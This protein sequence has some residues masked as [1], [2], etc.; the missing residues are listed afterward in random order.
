GYRI[1]L[2]EIEEVLMDCPPVKRAAVVVR[3]L[4]PGESALVAFVSADG[5][6]APPVGELRELLKRRLPETMVPALFVFPEQLALTAAGKVD[7]RALA[8]VALHRGGPEE[9]FVA[10]RSPS[11]E[12]L[13]GIWKEV[14]GLDQVGVHDNFFERGGHSLLATQVISRVRQVAQVEIPLRELFEAP[15]VEGLAARLD[16]ALRA[17]R[18][19]EFPPIDRVS[20]AK[21]LPLSFAQQR[22]W[23]LD[24][25]EP[26]SPAYNMPNALRLSGA[27]NA[28]RLEWIFN[29]LV[30]RHELLRTTFPAVAGRPRQVIAPRLELPLPLADLQ[31][32]AAER[33]QAEARRLAAEEALRPF[34]LKAGPLIRCTLLRL[35][36]EDQVLLVTMHHIISDGWSMGIFSRELQALYAVSAGSESA[37]PPIQYADFAHWQRRWLAGEVLEAELAY[38][39]ER[40]AGAPPQIELPIDRP[41]PAVQTLRGRV[42]G[43]ARSESLSGALAK[44]SREQGMTLF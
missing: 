4:V 41:R 44:L 3:E 31:N 5:E 16:V 32:L 13:A 28:A 7:R 1:E 43:T 27:V 38:W 2:G 9:G 14:L 12:L 36:D 37:P 29:A 26:A 39:R 20:R 25:F 8:T 10:P 40:L 34:D 30:R 42:L 22:L 33:R 15:T 24:Q 23:F 17:G 35:A 21:E 11:E 19:V 18:G 6:T